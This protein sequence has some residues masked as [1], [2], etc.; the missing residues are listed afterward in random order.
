MDP[1]PVAAAPPDKKLTRGQGI[2]VGALVGT[3]I[4]GVGL[5]WLLYSKNPELAFPELAKL[6]GWGVL[7]GSI[8]GGMIGGVY[9]AIRR[10]SR[11]ECG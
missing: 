7:V 9:F 8:A 1:A 11:T 10:I 3:V 2:L 6:A 5:P 4:G